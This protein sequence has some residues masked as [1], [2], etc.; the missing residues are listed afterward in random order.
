MIRNLLTEA[1]DPASNVKVASKLRGRPLN[2]SGLFA[3]RNFRNISMVSLVPEPGRFN[4]EPNATFTASFTFT[5][6]IVGSC[7]NVKPSPCFT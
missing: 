2:T 4:T 5:G 6:V 7:D 3:V 1:S